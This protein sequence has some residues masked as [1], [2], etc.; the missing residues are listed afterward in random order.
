M[1][2]GVPEQ[3]RVELLSVGAR[4]HPRVL[5]AQLLAQLLDQRLIAPVDRLIDLGDQVVHDRVAITQ[6]RVFGHLDRR[7]SSSNV[8]AG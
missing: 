1:L 5:L 6:V 8:Q 7:R 2:G 4:A 3:F